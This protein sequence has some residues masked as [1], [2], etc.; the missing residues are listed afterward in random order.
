MSSS[1]DQVLTAALSLPD[2]ERADLVDALLGTLEPDPAAP[3]DP[4]WLEEIERRS[5]EYDEGKVQGIPWDEV[6]KS[7]RRGAQSDG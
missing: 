7:L 4:A 6:R 3:L 1:F 2:T 5:K